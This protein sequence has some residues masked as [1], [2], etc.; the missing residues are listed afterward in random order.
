MEFVRLRG[1][2]PIL[3]VIVDAE[4]EF[5]WGNPVSAR[6]TTTSS[7]RSQIRAHSVFSAFGA[8]PTYLVTYPVATDPTAKAILGDFLLDGLCDI[9]AQLHPWVNPPFGGD[10]DE[11]LTF[12]GNLPPDIER[13]K[14]HI[15]AD[16]IRSNF[17]I[18]PT[19]YKAGRYGIGPATAGLLE[20][21]GFLVDTSLM[22]R[23]S[24]AET[25]GPD[26][27]QFDYMPFWFGK[28]RRLLELPVTRALRGLIAGRMPWAYAK[29]EEGPL[30]FLH[31]AGFL[32][33]T[34]LLER[35]TLSPEGSDLAAMCRL[36]YF[37]LNRGERI[38]N[39]SYHSPSLEPGNTPYVRNQ[40]DLA[41]FLDRVSGFLEFF[42]RELNGVL[43]TV[44]ELRDFLAPSANG[45]FAVGS[46]IDSRPVTEAPGFVCQTTID[47]I[48]LCHPV[49]M[50]NCLGRRN[51]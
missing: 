40:R 12:P 3:C 48:G 19:A 29:A 35:V 14:L 43:M 31:A 13:Q 4:E 39:L 51:S 32:A 22:P 1:T 34:G 9:G 50:K 17:D 41:I 6:N 42:T 49:G 5:H 38:F 21:Q 16:T 30:R 46:P 37:L 18:Q 20:D 8:K 28:R 47:V 25:G 10:V 26:F 23:T 33:R 15:L 44:Q 36:T 24:Y 11:R 27:S 2:R 45:M 7:I